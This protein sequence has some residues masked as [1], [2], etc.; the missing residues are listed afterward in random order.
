MVDSRRTST[1]LRLFARYLGP[2]RGWVALMFFTMLCNAGAQLALPR[3]IASFIDG[4][5]E[6]LPAAV[7][8]EIAL[9]FLVAALVSQVTAALGKYLATDLGMR[10]TNAL[11][12]DVLSHVLAQDIG[13]HNATT[14]GALIER[15]DGDATRL[16]TFLS[17]MLPTLV[18]NILLLAGTLGALFWIDWRAGALGL[19]YMPTV[20]LV[21]RILRPHSTRL[22]SRERERSAQLFGFIEEHLA[23]TEDVRANGAA[24]HVMR[25]FFMASRPWAAAMARAQIV[26]SLS[27]LTPAIIYSVVLTA[28]LAL[29]VW[30]IGAGALTLGSLVAL[31]RYTFLLS[32]P[33][34]DIG[35]QIME[36]LEASASA[37]RLNELLAQ[38]PV[39]AE[40]GAGVLPGGALEL[41]IDQVSFAY[42]DA[43]NNVLGDISLNLAPQRVLGLLGRTGSGKTTLTRLIARLYDASAGEIRLNGQNISGIAATSLRQRVTVVT[44][45]VQVFS[46]T[47]RDNIT[48]FDP[49]IDDARIWSALDKVGLRDWA[50]AL[51]RGLDTELAAGGGGVSAGQAQL[52]AFARAFLRDPGL[53]I[54]D[55]ASSRL[56]P[57]T[58]SQLERAIDAL[59]QGRTA[60]II[61]HRLKTVQRASDILVLEDGAIVEQGERAALA[62]DPSSRYYALLNYGAEEVLA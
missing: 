51:P 29:G 52:L 11:R 44:Q 45:E 53:V 35:R 58:E 56:D 46:A 26:G 34:N 60:I 30:L 9:T 23:G 7:M 6:R 49:E 21:V 28:M 15:I 27:W 1:L 40:N 2:R 20:W 17:H 8:G 22:F 10:A 32:Q 42:A 47:A 24:A 38:T 61:A 36:L 31:Y 54:L 19:A 59:L 57:A 25:R 3:L 16:N 5:T 55:E 33:L 39:L 37:A 4:A 48:L 14:P 43:Q 62:A 12:S 13:W 50:E 18:V 41:N